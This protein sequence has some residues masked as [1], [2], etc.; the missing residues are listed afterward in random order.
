MEKA[1]GLH[2]SL[3]ASSSSNGPSSKRRV[4]VQ[5][6]WVKVWFCCPSA[7]QPAEGFGRPG[8][9]GEQRRKI[10]SAREEGDRVQELESDQLSRELL[11]CPR[12]LGL[13]GRRSER[14]S[15]RAPWLEDAPAVPHVP[16]SATQ[17]LG[18]P[19]WAFSRGGSPSHSALCSSEPLKFPEI[20]FSDSRCQSRQEPQ[21]SPSTAPSSYGWKSEAQG[22]GVTYL[23]SHSEVEQSQPFGYLGDGRVRGWGSGGGLRQS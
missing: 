3:P 12:G 9:P 8:E 20:C 21:C 13:A 6:Q 14:P 22:R 15:A 5:T 4:C 19:F 11:A 10:T 7:P 18:L 16:S 17:S 23:R 1:T 2:P